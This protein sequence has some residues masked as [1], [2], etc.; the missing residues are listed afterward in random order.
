MTSVESDPDG[1]SL[2]R[3]FYD[4]SQLLESSE[5]SQARVDRVL[6]LLRALVPYEHAA[7][8]QALP[9][10][11]PRLFTAPGT[12]ANARGELLSTISALQARL[13]EARG[14]VSELPSN[15]GMH[16]AVPLIGVD[17]VVGLLF[18]RSADCTYEERHVRAL[19][20][21]AAKLAA[22]F[23]LLRALYLDAERTRQ[24]AQARH[25]AESA[26]RAKDEFLA[27]VSHELRS[28]LAPI[29]TWVDALRSNETRENDRRRA[30]EAIERSVRKQTKLI[31]DLLELS[32][33]AA[34]TVRLELQAVEPAALIRTAIDAVRE[35][36][37][38]KAL[39]F[40]VVLD[41]SVTPLIVDP[42]RL[43][44]IVV[45][46]VANAIKFTPD[47][48]RVEVRLERAGV[49][50]RIQ[51]IDSG[52]GIEPEKLA[53]LF[54]RFGQADTSTTRPY[55]GLG[56]G[57]A[58]VKDLVELHGGRVRAESTGGKQGA[59]FTVELP[60]A[61]VASELPSG[62]YASEAALREA[63]A[64]TGIRVL[65]VDNDR[66]IGEVLQVVLEGQGALV[67]IAASAAEALRM[68]ER[69]LPDVVLSDI[70]MPGENGYALMRKIIAREG[71]RAPPAAALS[72]HAARQDFELAIASGFRTLLGK[73]VDPDALIAAVASLAKR[74]DIVT[75][76]SEPSRP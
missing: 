21:V 68:M 23:S 12:P 25:A 28:P 27:L 62:A 55:G 10:C 5:D 43:S 46:L 75:R 42:H 51:V 17:Q 35:Q 65:V 19:S 36:A 37:K 49:L 54:R 34:A 16:L 71:D 67:T 3:T 50:A 6:A 32:G 14:P 44:Q 66:D 56:V 39:R 13:G 1:E 52:A 59:T 72:V 61:G 24:L 8:L 63:R 74:G 40:D 57:L 26:N 73:P 30:F 2:T 69:S 20:V 48:G 18:V 31:D 11:E 33:V 38:H 29:L 7:V 22:Y 4:I 76:C 47:G 53:G 15:S 41:E 70:A 45:S 60:L 9:D 64:L 58:L